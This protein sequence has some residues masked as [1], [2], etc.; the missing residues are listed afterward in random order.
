MSDAGTL[1]LV[2]DDKDVREM[3]VGIFANQGLTLLEAASANAA[4]EL[5][6]QSA[7]VVDVIISDIKMRE[8]GG[9]ELLAKIKASGL[10]AQKPQVIL[11]TGFPTI[12]LAKAKEF[13]ASDLIAKPFDSATLKRAVSKCLRASGKPALRG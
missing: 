10:L 3:L 7:V 8:G 13:G 5:L 11:I 9:F 4:F 1:L 6:R 2:E 12:N